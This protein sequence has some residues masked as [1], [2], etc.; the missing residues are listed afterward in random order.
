MPIKKKK[1]GTVQVDIWQNQNTHWVNS[2]QLSS[3]PCLAL[4]FLTSCRFSLLNSKMGII[5]P[6]HLCLSGFT[7]RMK[8]LSFVKF[9]LLNKYKEGNKKEVICAV[10]RASWQMYT[11]LDLG[12]LRPDGKELLISRN[13]L[14]SLLPG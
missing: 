1:N 11:E 6:G 10:G 3:A 2:G 8:R 14:L 9:D 4:Q 7:L 13:H 12:H 5:T